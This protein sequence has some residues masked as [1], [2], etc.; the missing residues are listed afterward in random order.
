MG[1]RSERPWVVAAVAVSLGLTGLTVWAVARQ[2]RALWERELADLRAVALS[3]VAHQ[4]AALAADL[5]RSFEAVERAWEV[6][7]ADEVDAW[8]STQAQWWLCALR[9]ADGPLC[10]PRTPFESPGP[11][12]PV[13]QPAPRPDLLARLH[14]LQQ[15][16]AS[17]DPLTQAA[18]L[19]AIAACEQQLGHPLAAARILGEAA[20]LL[21]STPRWAGLAFQ[22]EINR[23]ETLEAA[24][25]LGRAR[26]ALADLIGQLRPPPPARLSLPEVTRLA[27]RADALAVAPDDAMSTALAELRAAAQ[28]RAH[29][30]AAA[31][32]HLMEAGHLDSQVPDETAAVAWTAPDGEPALLFT[33]RL[34]GGTPMLPDPDGTPRGRRSLASGPWLVLASPARDV[35]DRYWGTMDE[36][37]QLVPSG[38]ASNTPTL[39]ELGPLFGNAV[40]V[41]TAAT[42]QRLDSVAHRQWGLVLATAL[43][44]AGAWALVLWM[45]MRAVA[46]QRELARLQGRFVADVSHELKTPLA[47]IRLLAE[48]LATQRLQ[49]PQ[50]M[51]AYHQ[52]ITREAE[53][54]TVL[55][56][57]ILDL[58]RIESGRKV[59]EFGACDLGQVAREAWALCEPQFAEGGFERRLD[60]GPHL[61]VIRA[62]G[63][64]LHQVLVNL[65]QNAY[66]YAGERKFV[67]LT[68]RREGYVMLLCVEDHGIGMDRGQLRRLG[69]SFFRADDARVR[70]QRGAGLGLAIV[71]HIVTAHGGKIDVQSRPG[72]GSTFTVWIPFQPEAE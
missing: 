66:R 52:T 69:E 16:A 49:D 68:V 26:E 46:R 70:E 54:L 72:Q 35:W 57:N 71:H 3:A 44:T 47:L 29:L 32:W 61:P 64:A 19:W 11:P 38:G 4:R 7:G 6:G 48:T 12:P 9:A 8:A 65:L 63:Q 1:Q 53:R 45:L 39:A 51:H 22:A 5:D 21:R 10:F 33:R 2:G 36:T 27:E 67:R 58:G 43:G 59:Y 14:E 60:I 34:T 40:L 41:P 25:D 24:G 13:S 50:R 18:T 20:Q 30:V 37:W 42:R 17:P 31:R 15:R 23:V 56:D 28:R 55:L 62:D